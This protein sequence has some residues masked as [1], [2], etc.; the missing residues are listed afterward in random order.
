[1]KKTGK[2]GI[3]SPRGDGDPPIPPPS[4]G[5]SACHFLLLPVLTKITMF[6]RRR[7][8]VSW[9]QT[10]ESCSNDISRLKKT[11]KKNSWC[12]NLKSSCLGWS[13]TY[14]ENSMLLYAHYAVRTGLNWKYSDEILIALVLKEP[15]SW[16]PQKNSGYDSEILWSSQS[17]IAIHCE[18]ECCFLF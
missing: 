18:L 16:S 7:H 12:L 5:I 11:K 1:M 9:E 13:G 4:M 14:S 8:C 6:S 17:S 15:L 3:F 10:T 2:C